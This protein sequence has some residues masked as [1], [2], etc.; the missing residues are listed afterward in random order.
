MIKKLNRCDSTETLPV[1]GEMVSLE[2]AKKAKKGQKGLQTSQTP[3]KPSPWSMPKGGGTDAGSVDAGK[4]PATGKAP[5][6]KQAGGKKGRKN[7]SF[8]ERSM[9]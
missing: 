8:G 9:R 7:G 3:T 4:A 1:Q 5:G 6:G 2:D